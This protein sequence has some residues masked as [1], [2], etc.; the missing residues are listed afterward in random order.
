[1]PALPTYE[2]VATG[3]YPLYHSLFIACRENGDREG[4]MFV[5]HL[6]SARGLRQVERA[7]V[8]PARQ[9]LREIYLNTNPIGE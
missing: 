5:T 2:N 8:V 4:G 3:V 7:G 1:L 9:V 6:S